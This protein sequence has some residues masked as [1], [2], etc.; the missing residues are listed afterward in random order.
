PDGDSVVLSTGI[1]IHVHTLS[2]FIKWVI[3]HE[4]EKDPGIRPGDIF[5]NND[6]FVSDVHQPDLMTI[7]PIFHGDELVAWA[8][9]V[10]HE[11]EIGGVVGG[12]NMGT[13]AERFGN[14]L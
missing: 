1:V 8:G 13:T 12:A 3:E 10:C 7:I 2:R 9:S 11:I 14:G 4:Y 5:V 6:P